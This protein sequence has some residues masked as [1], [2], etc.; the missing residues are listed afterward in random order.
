M[1]VFLGIYLQVADCPAVSNTASN[2]YCAD[3]TPTGSRSGTFSLVGGCL[4]A[5][6]GL[7][8]TFGGFVIRLSGGNPVAPYIVSLLTYLGCFVG[9]LVIPEALSKDRRLEAR[10]EK[11]SRA[12]Q[13]RGKSNSIQSKLFGFLKPLRL[14]MP[15]RPTEGSIALA[16]E[17]PEPAKR[18]LTITCVSLAYAMQTG[19]Y[20]VM[21]YKMLY[22]QYKFGWGPVEVSRARVASVALDEAYQPSSV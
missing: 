9:S 7:G 5:G 12:E 11:I 10:R 4:F 2:A 1:I 22:S 21:S 16:T 6:F 15:R 8:P 14:L 18:D 20:A 19:L 17:S 3:S 13:R